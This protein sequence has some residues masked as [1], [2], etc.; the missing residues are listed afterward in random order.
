MSKVKVPEDS[1]P[2]EVLFTFMISESLLYL[3]VMEEM[4]ELPRALC[5]GI[6]NPIPED[7]LFWPNH[8]CKGPPQYYYS[9]D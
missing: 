5:E 1:T 6:L 8:L 7:S 3:H 2:D 4:I 9:D